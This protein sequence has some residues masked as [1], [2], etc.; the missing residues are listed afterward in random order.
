MTGKMVVGC[1]IKSRKRGALRVTNEMRRYTK[2]CPVPATSAS[3]AAFD[4][5]ER[6]VAAKWREIISKLSHK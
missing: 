4:P 3:V 6:F 5:A 2:D 1:R